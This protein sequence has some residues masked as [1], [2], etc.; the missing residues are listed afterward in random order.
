MLARSALSVA[1]LCLLLAFGCASRRDELE[2][3]ALDGRDPIPRRWQTAVL[4]TTGP[5]G[6][7]A[8]GPGGRRVSVV[9]FDDATPMLDVD[10]DLFQETSIAA[11]RR[12][13]WDVDDD[14]VDGLPLVTTDLA[15]V[16]SVTET[17]NPAAPTEVC[18]ELTTALLERKASEWTP[19]AESRRVWRIVV[20]LAP[21][22]AKPRR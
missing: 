2:F 13:G 4:T 21:P 8:H 6:R 9:P 3:Q 17:R 15:L 7:P 22:R 20:A 11:L 14:P 5:L 16:G 1:V 18:V 12:A 19:R 10:V